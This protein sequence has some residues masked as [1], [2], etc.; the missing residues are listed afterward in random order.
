MITRVRARNFRSLENINVELGALTVLVGKNGAGKSSFVDVLRFI[1]DALSDTGGLGQAIAD[2]AGI[3]SIRRWSSHGDDQPVEVGVSLESPGAWGDYVF[4]VGGRESEYYVEREGSEAGQQAG[5][6]E[7]QFE[8]ARG[9]P[10]RWLGEKAPKLVQYPASMD[11]AALWLPSVAVFVQSPATTEMYFSLR[12]LGCYSIYP[13]SL[14]QPQ[15]PA[16]RRPLW[17]GAE[18]LGSVLE[19][20]ERPGGIPLTELKEVLGLIV[21]DIEDLRVRRLGGFLVTELKHRSPGEDGP[22]FALT[23]EADGSLRALALLTALYQQP[24]PSLIAI[25]EPELTIHPGAL[26]VLADVLREASTRGQVLV[27]TQSPDLIARFGADELR[28]VERV[29]G[30]T[31]IGPIAESQR[32]AIEDQLFSGGDLLRIEGLHRSLSTSTASSGG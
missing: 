11:P 6:A 1:R 29:N 20:A 21:D 8:S 15:R 5:I 25:E 3:D 7:L 9:V 4:S 27:T 31:Q 32:Q 26:G 13:N 17:D 28:I 30:T 10:N 16:R 22:W 23:Q 24:T 18:N 14:R 2:R 12:S 19:G